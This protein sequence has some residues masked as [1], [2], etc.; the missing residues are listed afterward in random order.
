MIRMLRDLVGRF[1]GE[2]YDFDARRAVV[3]GEV[4]WSPVIWAEMAALGILAAPFT[5]EHGGLGGGGEAMMVLMEG[6]GRALL[7]E[8]FVSTSVM[9]SVLFTQP[10]GSDSDSDR[11]DAIASGAM[12]LALAHDELASAHGEQSEIQTRAEATDQGY[13]LSGRKIVVRDAPS[14]THLVVSAKSRGEPPERM[15]FLVPIDAD[16]L[17]LDPYR[18]I[19]GGLAADIVLDDV[20]LPS[21][22]L[23]CS[24]PRTL[25]LVSR[26]LDEATVAVCAEGLGVMRVMLEQTVAYTGQREQFGRPLS[27]FQVPQHRFVDMYIE[28][29]QAHSLTLRAAMARDDPLAVSAAKIRVN[30]ALRTVSHGA[31]Q[32][33]GG[34]GT[35]EELSLGHYFRRATTIE[36][37]YGTSA[38]H[39]RRIEEALVA[40]FAA[41]AP[42]QSFRQAPTR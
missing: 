26:L 5:E 22:A 14:A 1:L 35:T 2:R 21:S 16:G 6:F 39:Y 20:S 30:Q 18:L 28:I 3:N 29:E 31:L 32:L 36:R 40:E 17:I 13:T 19:D 11:L 10:G 33:H 34:I 37:Q 7:V 25:P 9:G 8:P 12:R 23:L 4:G 24:G 38:Q 42:M 15:L 41:S 27:G